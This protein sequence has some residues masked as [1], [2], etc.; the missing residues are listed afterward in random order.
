MSS[1]K[2]LVQLSLQLAGQSFIVA[3]Q[4]QT[5][6][7]K[8]CKLLQICRQVLTRLLSRYQDVRTA[9]S[10]LLRQVWNKLLSPCCTVDDGNKLAT[11]CSNKT[12]VQAVRNK[13]LRA[14]CHQLV[15]RA[16]YT[17]LVGT[18]CCRSV[19]LV[20]QPC[21]KMIPACSMLT[22]QQRGTSSANTSCCQTVRFLRVQVCYAM[23]YCFKFA[24]LITMF[25]YK[26]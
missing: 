13:L 14:C 5:T 9:C 18:T 7:V 10:Q 2:A 3:C 19:S 8:T 15:R 12:I 21:Y 11:S 20:M 17:T 1:R 23:Q 26:L 24:M 22:C 25:C 6:H 16:D 4:L